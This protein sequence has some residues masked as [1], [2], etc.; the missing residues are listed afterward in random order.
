MAEFST[1]KLNHVYLAVLV[2]VLY[3]PWGLVLMSNHFEVTNN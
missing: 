2:S 3:A 1:V